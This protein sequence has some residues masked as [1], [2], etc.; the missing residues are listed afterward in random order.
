MAKLVPILSNDVRRFLTSNTQPLFDWIAAFGSPVYVLFPREFYR[1][2]SGYQ[3]AIAERGVDGTIAFATKVNKS[4]AFLETASACGIGADVASM[5]EL[6]AA[7]AKAIPGTRI[8]VTGPE[9]NDDLLVRAARAGCT[10]AVDS[11]RELMRLA[12]LH[13]RASIDEPTGV[14]VRL[15]GFA[16]TVFGDKG[17]F[18]PPVRENGRFGIPV[19]GWPGMLETLKLERVRTRVRF[20][21]F[22]FHIDNHEIDDRANAISAVIDLGFEARAAGLPFEVIDIG[23]GIPIQYLDRDAWRAFVDIQLRS[24]RAGERSTMFRNKDLG[25]RLDSS[26][27]ARGHVYA[28]EA[29]A[30]KDAFLAMLLDRRLDQETIG[31]QL[32]SGGIRL[33]IEPGRSLLD[34][35]GITVCSVKGMKRSSSG[36]LLLGLDMNISHMWDQ[37]IGSEFAVDPILIPKEERPTAVDAVACHLVG[38]LCLESDIL[39]SRK[40]EFDTTPCPGDLLVFPNTAGYQMDFI[41]SRMHQ[42]PLPERV[43]VFDHGQRWRWAL[44]KNFVSTDL[45]QEEDLP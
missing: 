37:M 26:G 9:K 44:D 22:S 18:V 28:H 23:G 1:N 42:K 4:A 20:L 32:R 41:E 19:E 36:D 14:L 3:K 17:P 29:P 45:L 31:E 16:V 43:A 40:V 34:Q 35:S 39:A 27:V 10:I 30:F 21:G 8:V 7:L 13:R 6:E 15:S 2:I 38:N 33:L 24:G 5:Q 11:E 25:L 12:D